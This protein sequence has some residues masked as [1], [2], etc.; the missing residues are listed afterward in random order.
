[1]KEVMIYDKM[2]LSAMQLVLW[3][4]EFLG[5]ALEVADENGGSIDSTVVARDF[6][7]KKFRE[8]MKK[9]ESSNMILNGSALMEEHDEEGGEAS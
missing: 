4:D 3:F 5:Y 9:E 8:K 6:V 2:E 1:M 7:V